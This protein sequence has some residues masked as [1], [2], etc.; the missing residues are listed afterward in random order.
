MSDR[1]DRK[2]VQ[3]PVGQYAYRHEAEFAAGFL[4][5]A[6]IPYRLQIDDPALGVPMSG[7]ATLWVAAMDERRARELLEVEGE[8]LE[9]EGELLE[10]EGEGLEV[11]GGGREAISAPGAETRPT[12]LAP[13]ARPE[14]APPPPTRGRPAAPAPSGPPTPRGSTGSAV[15][16]S[17]NIKSDLTLRHRL[18]A[19]TGSLGALG[20]LAIDAVRGLHT[21]VSVVIAV[22]A[23]ALLLIALVGRAPGP[24]G[25]LLSALSGDAP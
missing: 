19:L 13:P 4:E 24:L 22:I 20:V 23:A 1:E 9:V 15:D 5:D 16:L 25:S 8:L 10:V 18:V 7:S 6:G 14:P 12:P 11:E 21:V 2:L 17:D 3:I